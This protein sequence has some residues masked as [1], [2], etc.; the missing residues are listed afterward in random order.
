MFFYSTQLAGHVIHPQKDYTVLSS[1]IHETFK[2]ETIC[3]PI[4]NMLLHPP[5]KKGAFSINT[6]LNQELKKLFLKRPYFQ[7]VL[8]SNTQQ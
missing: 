7:D 1:W 3:I 5:I 6:A 8:S 2:L 4:L